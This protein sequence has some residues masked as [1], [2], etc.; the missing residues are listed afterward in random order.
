MNF[1]VVRVQSVCSYV[2]EFTVEEDVD[3]CCFLIPNFCQNRGEEDMLILRL[4]QGKKEKR[5]KTLETK[6]S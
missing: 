5:K 4:K 2:P 6:E 3:L 1:I